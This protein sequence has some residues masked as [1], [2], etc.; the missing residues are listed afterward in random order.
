LNGTGEPL[1][2]LD[3]GRLLHDLVQ[4]PPTDNLAR[5]NAAGTGSI[6]DLLLA[7]GDAAEGLALSALNQ[8]VAAADA[9]VALA[10]EAGGARARARARRAAAQSLAY[11]GR[12]EAAL[13]RCREA[14]AIASPKGEA[15]E[16]ARARL[17]MLHA[18]ANLGRFDEAIAAG[19]AAR[20]ALLGGGEPALAARADLNLGAVHAMRDAPHLALAHFDR[21][22][23]AFADDPVTLA[24][25]DSNRG[26]ALMALDD[27]A[28][29]ERAFAAAVEA[30][31]SGGQRVLAAIAEGN[32]AYLATRQG[33]LPIALYHFER[34]RR[35]F[36]QEAA[37]THLARL[38]AEQAHAFAVLGLPR[39]ALAV[40]QRVLPSLDAHGL[41]AEAAEAR[42]ALGGVLQRLGRVAEADDALSRAEET[43]RSLGQSAALGR[44]ALARAEALGALGRFGEAIALADAAHAALADRPAESARA[45]A[46][47]ARLALA[48]GERDAAARALDAA[49]PT[50]ERLGLA[51]VLADL[52]LTR[53]R[54][55][56]AE[57]KTEAARPAFRAAIAQVERVR[58]TLQAER[59]RSAYLADRVAAYEGLVLTSLAAGA[60]AG[61]AE[62]FAIVERAKSRTL[63]DTLAGAFGRNERTSEA[64]PPVSADTAGA[65]ASLR[66]EL[67]SLRAE[68]NWHYSRL[69]E[70][71]PRAAGLVGETWSATVRGL[72]ARI[73][74]VED[75]L[76]AAQ[77]PTGLLAPTV[78]LPETRDA[79]PPGAA[80]LEYFMAGEEVLGFFV[81]ARGNGAI[82]VCRRLTTRTEIVEAVSRFRFQIN[83]ALAG[84]ESAGRRSNRLTADARRALGLLAEP[85]LRPFSPDLDGVR[86][87]AVVPHGPLHAIPFHALSIAGRYLVEQ[88]D[89]AQIASASLLTRLVD[90]PRGAAGAGHALV[91]GVPD[92]RAPRIREEAIRVASELPRAT[93]L[94]GTAATVDAVHAAL[95]GA[96]VAHFACHGRFSGNLPAA[97]GLKLADRWL[98]VRETAELPLERAH[99]TLSG[100]DTG[101]ALVTGG[102]ELVG[103]PRALLAAGAASVLV[104]LWPVHDAGTDELMVDFYR[105][106]QGA[107]SRAAALRGAQLAALDARP[108]PVYWAPFVLGGLPW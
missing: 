103:L 18:L 4:F 34:A 24:S 94:L 17:A 59:F 55:L 13:V 70:S 20:S 71:D 54:L 23:P 60:A 32:L 75:R 37:P 82:R 62:A 61:Y 14:I 95:P 105:R 72:E 21:A 88:M 97:S 99:V 19:E 22:R 85:L 58:G 9:L 41:A 16:A 89:V 11:A 87:L 43:F 106:W 15:V 12:F 69:A 102:D 31:Q 26:N 66:T 7:L 5:L 39:D 6:D 98:T 65:E 80:L 25:L 107:T 63:L 96:S 64:I 48:A 73:D 57:G 79:L 8:A 76:A 91:V 84:A 52:H 35:L 27:F 45:L 92:D 3:L 10:D 86:H 74:A 108:H 67:A 68:L 40:F 93:S 81:P 33:R 77:R 30:F 101:R 56:E 83:R 42:A 78:G 47:R 49:L 1:R 51:P 38:E 100:C 104:S 28:R 36:E 44:V 53:G 90:Q 50:G 29:A 2:E 46:V